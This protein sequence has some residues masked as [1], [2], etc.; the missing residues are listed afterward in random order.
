[1][2]GLGLRMAGSGFKVL[3]FRAS[4]L[5]EKFSRHGLSQCSVL[6]A[7]KGITIIVAKMDNYEQHYSTSSVSAMFSMAP[8]SMA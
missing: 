1:M 7:L 4:S 2:Q 3:R 5:E 6:R 8:S